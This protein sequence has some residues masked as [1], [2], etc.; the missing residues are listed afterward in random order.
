M[1]KEPTRFDVILTTNQYGDILSDMAAAWGGGLGF[2][3]ALNFGEDM[4][5]AEPV[6]GSAPDI[7][8][9]GIA[10]P[11]AMILSAALLARYRWELPEIADRIEQ[12][13]RQTLQDGAYTADVRSGGAVSTED[14]TAQVC[15]KLTG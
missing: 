5:I 9:R 12:A 13:V 10:N 15:A 4:G 6:H 11:T 7:A 2:V 14:F 3:P 1:V 8:G